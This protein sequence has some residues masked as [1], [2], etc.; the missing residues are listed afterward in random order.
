MKRHEILGR[1]LQSR[2]DLLQSIAHGEALA[3]KILATPGAMK[4][5]QRASHM[6]AK[7]SWA[8][9]EH[10]GYGPVEGLMA[11]LEKGVD[12][13]VE[14]FFGDWWKGN[15]DDAKA[16][17]KS[18]LDRDLQWGVLVDALLFCGLTGRWNDAARI[19]SWFDATIELEY[20]TLEEGDIFLCIPFYLRQHPMMGAHDFYLAKVRSSRD[21][22]ER[23][24]CAA[25][26][27]TVAKD[28]G[29]FDKALKESVAHFLKV[30][31]HDSPNP[32]YWMAMH[33]SLV[34]LIAE[35]NGLTFPKLPEKSDA[36]VIRRQTI[37]LA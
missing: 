13:A 35:R 5:K 19:C 4:H 26:E 11:R 30:E 8:L 2:A 32:Y 24:L 7:V 31:A 36:A 29:A 37:G 28:Q 14:Y 12:E 9:V 1:K 16:L 3:L 33:Q 15:E 6:D 27:A 22:G 17:D 23:L 25:W 20:Q 21:K 18:R 34:W 10:L